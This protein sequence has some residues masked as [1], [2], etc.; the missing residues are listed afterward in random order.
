MLGAGK[1]KIPRGAALHC[2]ASYDGVAQHQGLIAD[3]R[4]SQNP[5]K[6]SL[7]VFDDRLEVLRDFLFEEQKPRKE[8]RDFEFGVAWLMWMLGFSVAQAGG[9]SRTSD[10]ADIIATTPKGNFLIV[11][12]TTRLLNAESKLAKLVER[13]EAVR[14]RIESTGHSHLKLLPVIVTAK[15]MDEVRADLEQAQKLGVTVVAKERLLELLQQTI[16]AEDADII[17]DQ[18]EAIQPEQEQ[19]GLFTGQ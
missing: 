19:L 17:F 4:N 10:A 2:V 18:W 12:C 16:V 14:R 3:L 13:T 11:E 9:T 5:R 15:S 1:I 7:E 8:S 6:A